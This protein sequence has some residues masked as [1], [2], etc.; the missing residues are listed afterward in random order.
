M[1]E[2][3]GNKS[4]VEKIQCRNLKKKILHRFMTMKHMFN[5]ISK[6]LNVSN[7][8]MKTCY[9]ASNVRTYHN[10]NVHAATLYYK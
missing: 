3:T 7:K 5:R 4:N 10:I 6:H 8:P 9:D 1:K 2:I